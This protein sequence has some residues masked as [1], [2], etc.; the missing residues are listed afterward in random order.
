MDNQKERKRQY[1]FT[2]NKV[3]VI[4]LE[5][6]RF[7]NTEQF[8]KFAETCMESYSRTMDSVRKKEK[9]K[10]YNPAVVKGFQHILN[11]DHTAVTLKYNGE[12]F[13][14]L[15]MADIQDMNL[16]LKYTYRVFYA[17]KRYSNAFVKI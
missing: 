4:I 15:N 17:F 7:N 3:I 2:D 6:N 12:I 14:R 8:K 11:K 9:I 5:L 16:Q 10:T 13:A 1:V